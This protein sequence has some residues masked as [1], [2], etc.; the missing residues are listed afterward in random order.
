M[1]L[2]GVVAYEANWQ[3]ILQQIACV[4]A[5][6]VVLAP[7]FLGC[8]WFF[9]F[10]MDSIC[11]LQ[12]IKATSKLARCPIVLIVTFHVRVTTNLKNL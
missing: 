8:F 2:N 9:L 5:V 7:T 11:L 12:K 6:K 1:I 3:K 10:A 4:L